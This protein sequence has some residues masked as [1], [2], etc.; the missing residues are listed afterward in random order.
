M[1][2]LRSLTAQLTAS[3]ARSDELFDLVIPDAVYA[4]PIPERNRI[5]FYLGHL[6]AFDWNLICQ[7]TFE[8]D[9]FNREFDRLF[10]FGIDPTDGNLPQDRPGDWPS[11]AEIR[12]YDQRV[13]EKVDECL[14]RSSKEHQ[15]MFHVAIEHRM[16]H[17]ETLAYMLHNL[18]L[19]QKRLRPEMHRPLTQ[20]VTHSQVEIPAGPVSM[21]LSPSEQTP[22][23]W[24]NEFNEHQEHVD[25]FSI[26]VYNVTNGQFLEFIQAGGYEDRALWPDADW[27]WIQSTNSKCP[28]FWSQR[29]DRWFLRLM[30]DEIELPMSWP[31]YVSHAEASAYAS[32]RGKSLP[33]E[34]QYHRAAFGSRDRHNRMYPWGDDAPMPHHGNFDFVQWSPTHVNAHPRGSSAFGVA[35]LMSNGW[36]WTSTLFQPFPGFEAFQFYKGYSADFF[37]GK[38][39]VLKG[40]SPRTAATLIRRSFRN[41]FQAHFPVIYATFRC[42]GD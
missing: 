42:V 1:D 11:V 30:F 3:R 33:S 23:G 28:V 22:F 24:D 26:D 10:A 21:G 7:H 18:P 35:D 4:R 29:N 38:H 32:W 9:S 27:N 17:E 31:V 36:E 5:I 15:L 19:N 16:M 25:G 41:F 2:R 37:D 20:P 13:R 12:R 39:Y 6:D 34:A 40:A 8:M 14:K